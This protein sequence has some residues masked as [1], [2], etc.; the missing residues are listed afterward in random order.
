M[1]ENVPL[2]VNAYVLIVCSPKVTKL[3]IK[4]PYRHTQMPKILQKSQ[5]QVGPRSKLSAKFQSLWFW[6]L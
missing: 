2:R 1:W 5:K 6:R 4:A 3:K